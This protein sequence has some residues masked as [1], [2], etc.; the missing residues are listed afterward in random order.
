MDLTTVLSH[1]GA[2]SVDDRLRVLR[3]TWEGVAVELSSGERQRVLGDLLSKGD[4]A[5]ED[6]GPL[7]E[8]QRNELERRLADHLAHPTDVVPWEEVKARALARRRQ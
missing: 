3:A 8:A 7:T 2:L 4:D 1:I 6:E 5:D